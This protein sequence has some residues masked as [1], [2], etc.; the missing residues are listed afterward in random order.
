MPED[1][2]LVFDKWLVTKAN[3]ML[4]GV[5]LK[6]DFINIIINISFSYRQTN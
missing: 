4:A 5:I 1:M 3:F 2:R 6:I